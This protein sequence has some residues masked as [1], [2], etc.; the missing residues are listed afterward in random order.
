MNNMWY[1]KQ[2]PLIG[3]AGLSGGPEGYAFIRT[4]AY[5]IDR[6]LRLNQDDTAHLTR[7]F[8]EEGD[9]KTFT[10]S[11]W[12]K[13]TQTDN[14]PGQHWIWMVGADGNNKFQLCREGVTQ[15]NFE[16]NHSSSQ[17][18]RFYTAALLRDPAAWY[19]LVLSIDTTQSTDTERMKFYINGTE[20][21]LG[22][23]G[24]STQYPTQ[25]LD[26][27]W[28]ENSV[29]HY[30]GKR[31]YSLNSNDPSDYYMA[32][33]YYID[34]LALGPGSFGQTDAVTGQ[35]IAK[36]YSGSYGNAGY[37]LDFSDNSN[38][39]AATLGKDSSGNSN[40]WTPNN[41][42]VT[43]GKT[44]DS[45][46]D[47]PT[48]NFCTLNPLQTGL[49]LS[50]SDGN[51]K[52]DW[53]TDGNLHEIAAATFGVK[54]GVWYWE[55]QLESGYMS[56]SVGCGI[57]RDDADIINTGSGPVA[58]PTS[59]AAFGYR[60]DG[61]KLSESGGAEAYGATWTSTDDVIG[62]L[63]DF[64]GATGT[65]T[66]YKNGSTQGSA[67]TDITLSQTQYWLPWIGGYGSVAG[68][69]SKMFVNFG[70]RAFAQTIPTGAKSLCTSNL[71]KSTILKG[72]DYFNTALY[73]GNGSTNSVTGL[74]FQ[75]D[76]TWVKDRDDGTPDNWICVDSER[77]ISEMIKINEAETEYEVSGDF[78]S[79]N[80][81]GFSFGDYNNINQSGV[82]YASWSWKKS[83]T[84]GTDIVTYT[85]DDSASR[86]ISH[87]LG[88]KPD[89][90][91]VKSRSDTTN[92]MTYVREKGAGG[93]VVLNTNSSW[94]GG[95]GYDVPFA[96]TDP[97]SSVFSVGD[98]GGNWGTNETGETYFAYLFASIPGFSKTGMYTAVSG[99]GSTPN[100]NGA[101]VYTGFQPA[102][103][104]VK[105]L[106]GNGDWTLKDSV[107]SPYNSRLEM[108]FPNTQGTEL[109]SEA[110]DFVSNGFKCRSA[111][112]YF[113]Y[114]DGANF[115]YLAFAEHP[116]KNSNGA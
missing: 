20:A 16:C 79:F 107:R 44:N 76:I 23:Q 5:S 50:P 64:S 9:R 86:T 35:W 6:S 47:T 109:N 37:R 7:T 31:S 42:S 92:W 49:N 110:I 65:L 18:A 22:G 78:T 61:N 55:M 8:D 88:A 90:I 27:L 1:P 102:F 115:L 53:I 57:I 72:I 10:L 63:M 60:N 36:K 19:H 66:F 30:M 112:G 113:D 59:F 87:S 14:S 33:S 21:T 116:F 2:K 83:A 73:A 4:G 29:T 13:F 77:G 24:V 75:P 104:L 95:S 99:S 96:N 25:D 3:L 58:S 80:S 32:D 114:P 43:A 17:V 97:T 41:F 100:N 62:V 11:G 93:Y 28:G 106:D 26:F 84:A 101:F 94:I 70:Q 91:W 15:L 12:Y 45:L 71:D 56:D 54:S 68:N 85:G 105:R 103:L 38:T 82:N 39:T 69:E 108:L 89:L 74:S 48:N 51:L 52:F 46:E 111:S 67:F 98:G 81:D 34:G 40:N